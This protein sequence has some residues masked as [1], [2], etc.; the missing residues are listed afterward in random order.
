MLIEDAV[1]NNHEF[2]TSLNLKDKILVTD[3][4]VLKKEQ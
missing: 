3:F 1:T 2:M 4:I